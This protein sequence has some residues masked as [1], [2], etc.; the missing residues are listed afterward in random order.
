MKTAADVDVQLELVDSRGRALRSRDS[1]CIFRLGGNGHDT[2]FFFPAKKNGTLV[3]WEEPAML[4][5]KYAMTVT[6]HL[7]VDALLD[8]L[9]LLGVG[10]AYALL[11]VR[12]ARSGNDRICIICQ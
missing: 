4:G 8:A 12:S 9:K 5:V 2:L 11:K 10:D 7:D 1:G 6:N 3:L